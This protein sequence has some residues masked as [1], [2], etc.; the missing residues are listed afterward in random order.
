[1]AKTEL[2]RYGSFPT[3]LYTAAGENTIPAHAHA[4]SL[5]DYRRQPSN[6]KEQINY[7]VGHYEAE[8]KDQSGSAVG[9]FV[10]SS[11]SVQAYHPSAAYVP[12]YA[13]SAIHASSAIPTTLTQAIWSTNESSCSI[14]NNNVLRPSPI[15]YKSIST[16]NSLSCNIEHEPNHFS[17]LDPKVT[18]VTFYLKL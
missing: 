13:S 16:S 15:A 2:F 9:N 6:Y 12:P 4:I 3:G 18:T 17:R 10:V 7:N 14:E 1:M 8:I 11:P 5:T